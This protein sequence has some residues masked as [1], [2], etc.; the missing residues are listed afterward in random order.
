MASIQLGYAVQVKESGA[1]G[2]LVEPAPQLDAYEDFRDQY[3]AD[4]PTGSIPFWGSA[5]DAWDTVVLGGVALPGIATPSGWLEQRL[6]KKRSPKKHGQTVVFNGWG[7]AQV[8]VRLEIWTPDQWEAFVGVVKRIVIPPPKK[9]V[10]PPLS[11]SHPAV[12]VLGV[13]AVHVEKIYMPKM[14]RPGVMQI[15]LKCEQF[16]PDELRPAAGG[17]NKQTFDITTL[18]PGALNRP[19]GGAAP[20]TNPKPS[21]KANLAGP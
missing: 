3:A 1:G 6:F 14:I 12:A 20:T 2:V 8:E 11:I 4:Q 10:P 13:T 16:L 9:G 19:A 5:P 17:T 18:G 15:D 7:A 21:T